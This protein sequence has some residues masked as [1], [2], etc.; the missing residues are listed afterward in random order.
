VQP[1]TAINSTVKNN[2]TLGFMY[3][4]TIYLL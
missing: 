4:P 1:M 3:P 2:V